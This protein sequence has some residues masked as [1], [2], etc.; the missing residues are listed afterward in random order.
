MRGLGRADSGGA[1]VDAA[2]QCVGVIDRATQ[3]G[4]RHFTGCAQ[5]VFLHDASHQEIV[6]GGEFFEGVAF[7]IFD[8]LEAGV[9]DKDA[10]ANLRDQLTLGYRHVHFKFPYRCSRAN[11]RSLIFSCLCLCA[12][13]CFQ[14]N[15]CMR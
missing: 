9:D 11:A 15:R 2:T 10:C 3:H 1:Q 8:A 13:E 6:E 14:S 7:R 5:R 4:A 12:H